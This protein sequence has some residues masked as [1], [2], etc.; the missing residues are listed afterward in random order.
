MKTFYFFYQYIISHRTYSKN[1]KTHLIGLCETR[2]N[3]RH[4]AVNAFI[5]LFEPII[6]SLKNIQESSHAILSKACSLLAAAEK[7]SFVISL[8]VRENLLSFTLQL[9]HYL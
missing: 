7:Y 8:L 6:V 4:K 5:Q 3:Q 1:Q 2:F 9:S